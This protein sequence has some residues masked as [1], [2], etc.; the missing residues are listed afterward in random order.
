[1]V[2]R[3]QVQQKILALMR[4]KRMLEEQVR[5]SYAFNYLSVLRCDEKHYE[6]TCRPIVT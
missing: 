4:E 5:L 3:V 1:M 6:R 2:D